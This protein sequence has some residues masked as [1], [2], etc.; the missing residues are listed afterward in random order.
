MGTLFVAFVYINHYKPNQPGLVSLIFFCL[1][2]FSISI[3]PLCRK[4]IVEADLHPNF[5]IKGLI[6]EAKVN[7]KTDK[8][9]V[10]KDKS[11][12]IIHLSLTK[13]Y[14]PTWKS[15]QGEFQIRTL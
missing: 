8:R 10:A 7:L 1:L 6:E 4:K 3:S 14:A 5:L 9:S 13:S 12:Q 2:I 15:R 11:Y